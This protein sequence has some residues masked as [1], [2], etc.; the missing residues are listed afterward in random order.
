MFTRKKQNKTKTN[1]IVEMFAKSLFN[2]E[3]M[4]NI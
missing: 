1:F 3:K 4:L 2:S